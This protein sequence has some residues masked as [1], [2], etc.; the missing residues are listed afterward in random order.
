MSCIHIFIGKHT[1]PGWIYTNEFQNI[2]FLKLYMISI[3]YITTTLTTVGYGDISSNS[4]LEIYFRIILLGVG[5]IGYSWIISSISNGINKENYAS[6]NFENECQIL[7]EIRINHK[8]LPYSL[9]LNIRNH[10][11]HF[12]FI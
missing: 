2:S 10:I 8:K 7:E 4:I 1:F 6:I 9:Y 5:I 3:Y 11:F 12:L